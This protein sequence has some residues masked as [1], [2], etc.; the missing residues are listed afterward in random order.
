[1][2]IGIPIKYNNKI[3]IM[4]MNQFYIHSTVLRL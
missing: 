3:D 2:W 4:S 1:M